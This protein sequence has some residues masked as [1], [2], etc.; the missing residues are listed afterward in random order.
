MFPTGWGRKCALTI[1]SSYVGS[2]LSDFPVLFTHDN[3]PAEIF[4]NADN[5]GGDLRFSLDSDGNTPLPCEV[6]NFDTVN[7]KAEIWV[8]V[9]SVSSAVDTVI[10]VWYNKAGETQP[11]VTDT[12][13]RN[14]VWATDYILVSHNGG[15]TNSTGG[16]NGTGYNSVTEGDSIGKTGK[17]TSYNGSN[18]YYGWADNALGEEGLSY[19]SLSGWYKAIAQASKQH[20]LIAKFGSSDN[21]VFALSTNYGGTGSFAKNRTANQYFD[22]GS[23]T[24]MG[25]DI[26]YRLDGMW[27]G[28]TEW[29]TY[30]DATAEYTI[31]GTGGGTTL[32]KAQAVTM[33]F[34]SRYS[35]YT[36]GYMSEIRIRKTANSTDIITAEYAN[37]NSPASFVSTGTP[38]DAGGTGAT[39]VTVTPTTESLAI[40]APTPTVTAVRSVVIAVA[41][42]VL[43]ISAPTPTIATQTSAVVQPETETITLQEIAPTVSTGVTIKPNAESLTISEPSPSVTAVKSINVLAEAEA[44]SLT[45]PTP[46]VL[47]GSSAVVQPVT[48]TLSLSAPAPIIKAGVTASPS[49]E[50][51]TISAPAPTISA[52]KSVTISPSVSVLTITAPTSTTIASKA[53][54]ITPE[55]GILSITAP[56]P[57]VV[58]IETIRGKVHTLKLPQRDFTVKQPQRAFI[59]KQPPREFTLKTKF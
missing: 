28:G 7:S 54:I 20:T 19:L 27:N 36:Y 34:I 41:V 16:T 35:R 40:S 17:A 8:K 58:F 49:T 2:N 18:Q 37:Q 25:N 38:E 21:Y 46:T 10:Y 4:A 47:T 15:G 6:V 45:A 59:L 3:L 50:S 48:E 44:L 9:P 26:W 14:A 56:E 13:G 29:K 52:V 5:G 11:D 1:Q 22:G 42:S 57:S 51:L 33:G 23:A 55:V 31:T 12:Y 24:V 43:T 30:I 32:N 53:I 39:G